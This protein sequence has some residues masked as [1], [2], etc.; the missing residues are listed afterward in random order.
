MKTLRRI[1]FVVPSLARAGAEMQVVSLVSGLDEGRFDKTLAWFETRDDLLSD[2]D[3]SVATVRL[4]RSGR[5]D[6]G[7]ARQ[8]AAVIDQNEIEVVHC[9]LMISLFYA[10]LALRFSRRKPRM[11][12]AIHTTKN[13]D[14][15]SD[16]YD[17]VLYRWMLKDCAKVIFVCDAQREHWIARFPFLA[18]TASRIYNGIDADY[19]SPAISKE[20]R[21]AERTVFGVAED[22]IVCLCVAAMRPEKGHAILLKAMAVARERSPK[23]QLYLAGDGVLRAEL[24]KCSRDLGLYQCVHFLGM[25]TDIR[26]Y[27]RM[28]DLTILPSTAVETFS[29]AM[30]ESLAT[31]VPVLATDIGGVREAVIEGQTGRVVTPRDIGGLADALVDMSRSTSELRE[32]GRRGR[33]LVRQRFTRQSMIGEVSELLSA[34]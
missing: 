1:L 16:V 20:S 32:L 27:L 34:L 31:E 15:R 19:F 6:L 7:L 18:G 4:R 26:R 13:R 8:I 3:A 12:A 10:W 28:A 25:V 2:V 29:M 5:L 24:E 30:L 17:W 21:R 23:L 14:F 11:V 9:T 33:V 22:V